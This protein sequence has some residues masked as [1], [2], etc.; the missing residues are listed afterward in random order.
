M[1]GLAGQRGVFERS[2]RRSRTQGR[3]P[4]LRCAKWAGCLTLDWQE[5]EVPSVAR[6]AARETCGSARVRHAGEP[7]A[8]T[9]RQGSEH[10][11]S[12]PIPASRPPCRRRSGGRSFGR[13]HH[14]FAG[15]GGESHANCERPGRGG[16]SGGEDRHH[17]RTR[18]SEPVHRVV[19]HCL[20]H[21][22]AGVLDSL[23]PR[24]SVPE[25]GRQGRRQELGGLVRRPH[26]D[27][28]PQ[29]GH[30]LARRRAGDRRGRRLHLQLHHRERDVG[31]HRL[32]ERHR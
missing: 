19:G 32:H 10:E 8:E 21:F 20:L 18:Q 16:Q 4:A 27:L 15:D 30:H 14:L 1:V 12:D 26:L 23:R 22:L 2:C 13:R 6:S 29:R 25:V 5:P 7:R 9:K 17:A 11:T 3:A 31:L 28:P 24:L